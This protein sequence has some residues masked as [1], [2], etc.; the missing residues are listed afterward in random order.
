MTL[1]SRLAAIAF[2]LCLSWA[3]PAA[4]QPY[5]AKPIRIICAFPVGG[6]ADIYGAGGTIAA[7]NVAKSAPDGYTLVMG[8]VG[9]HAVNVSLFSRLP[10]DPVKDFAAVALVLEAEGLLVV[11]PSVPAGADSQ[12][13]RRSRRLKSRHA[14]PSI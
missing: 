8:S 13:F 14:N 3:L 5:P 2:V 6:I 4:A 10:Y 1:L 9:T 11:H 12:G 7:E